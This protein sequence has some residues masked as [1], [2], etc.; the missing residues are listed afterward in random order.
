MPE[1]GGRAARD[2]QTHVVDRSH[3]QAIERLECE[4]AHANGRLRA[5]GAASLAVAFAEAGAGLWGPRE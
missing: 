5:E 3:R 4:R 2:S 1:S